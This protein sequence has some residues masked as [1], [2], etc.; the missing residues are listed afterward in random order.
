[1]AAGEAA[2]SAVYPSA[3]DHLAFPELLEEGLDPHKV[4]EVW[5]IGHPDPNHW[6][7]ITDH[8]DRANRALAKHSSQISNRGE[9]AKVM[10][11]RRRKN[12][13]DKSMQ[14]AER[15]RRIIVDRP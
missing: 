8:V 11:E 5:I 13:A 7:D 10:N 4:N 14:Y 3:R 9:M 12:A 6:G 15:F 2:L 1:M